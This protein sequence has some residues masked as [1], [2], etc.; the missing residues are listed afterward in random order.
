MIIRKTTCC[1]ARKPSRCHKVVRCGMGLDPALCACVAKVVANSMTYPIDTIKLLSQTNQ[2]PL[3]WESIFNR[4][5]LYKGYNMFLP[6]NVSNNVINHYT[7]FNVYKSIDTVFQNTAHTILFSSLISSLITCVYKVPMLFLVRNKNI[8]Q[9]VSLAEF[10]Q[11]KRKCAHTFLIQVAEDVPE[12]LMRFYMNHT[13]QRMC[14]E[15]HHFARALIIGVFM[16]VLLAPL[17]TLKTNLLCRAHSKL[18]SFVIAMRMTSTV[19]NNFLFFVIF[20]HFS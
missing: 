13:L 2:Q 10:F 20:N 5:T 9:T 16:A 12:T 1:I 17:D 7:Y 11:N 3:R 15:L 8:G 4:T 19:L 18:S 6:Y 14:P